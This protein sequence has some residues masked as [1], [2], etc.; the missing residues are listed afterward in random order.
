MLAEA[1]G[2]L[3]DPEQRLRERLWWFWSE[4]DLEWARSGTGSFSEQRSLILRSLLNLCERDPGFERVEEWTNALQDWT[5]ELSSPATLDD[6]IAIDL[7]TG[8]DR[9]LVESDR[10]RA[11]HIVGS[12]C[13]MLF[14]GG[15]DRAIDEQQSRAVQLGVQI[16]ERLGM[17]VP[18]DVSEKLGSWLERQL[19][20]ILDSAYQMV[21]RVNRTERSTPLLNAPAVEAAEELATDVISPL[22]MSFH[23][24]IPNDVKVAEAKDRLAHLLHLVAA[25][26][27]WTLHAERAGQLL[28]LASEK[29]NANSPLAARIGSAR[30]KLAEG[31]AASQVFKGSKPAGSP[32]L[33]TFNGIGARF[34]GNSEWDAGTASYMTTH[35]FVLLFIPLF[36]L[37]RYRVRSSDDK[38]Y[39]ILARY[40]LKRANWWHSAISTAVIVAFLIF[41]ISSSSP[42]PPNSQAST[43]PS[44]SPSTGSDPVSP[45]SPSPLSDSEI[46]RK[47]ILDLEIDAGREEIEQLKSQIEA[48]RT[49]LDSWKRRLSQLAAEI[50]LMESGESDLDSDS[51]DLIVDEH[52]D[53]VD[54]YNRL[55][56]E[57]KKQIQRHNELIVIDSDLVAEYNEL[58]QR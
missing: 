23:A 24:A 27:T 17:P 6:L 43:I 35:Y 26:R 21:G 40:P 53:L 12:E 34:Y 49:Q 54:R 19:S 30:E 33:F 42:A 41:N 15:L 57:R 5:V 55:L 25:A 32:T 4:A 9:N 56:E 47:I 13:L 22:V 48:D 51:Y 18:H 20:P 46:V 29:V 45:D 1:L 36:P 28:N 39:Q 10:E 52:N 8:F 38:S 16:I 58:V 37:G 14:Y 11:R 44:P 7:R 31:Q 2:R 3:E 50:E